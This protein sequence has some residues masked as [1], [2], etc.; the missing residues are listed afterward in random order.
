[1]TIC[2]QQDSKSEV[3]SILAEHTLYVLETLPK[4]I[5]R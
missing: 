3:K 2:L 1:M 5:S 4:A